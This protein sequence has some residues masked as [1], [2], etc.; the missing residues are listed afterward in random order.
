MTDQTNETIL[1]MHVLEGAAGG[2]AK[3]SGAVQAALDRLRT[4]VAAHFP[5][6][7]SPPWGTDS[8]AAFGVDYHALEET[9]LPV[10]ESYADQLREAGA[11]LLENKADLEDSEQANVKRLSRPEGVADGRRGGA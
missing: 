8:H 2:L 10:L 1:A 4:E 7:T 5:K 11:G 9:G 6:G 3:A